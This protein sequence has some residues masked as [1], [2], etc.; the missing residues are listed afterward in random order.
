MWDL[1]QDLVETK[2]TIGASKIW[3]NACL[4]GII[5]R[6]EGDAESLLE[7]GDL[8]NPLAGLLD[9]SFVMWESPTNSVE[10]VVESVTIYNLS[11]C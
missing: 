8:C 4:I 9:E 10:S 2:K 5:A 7:F 6:F 11:T 1:R 3:G